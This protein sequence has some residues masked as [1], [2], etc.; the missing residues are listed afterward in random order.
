MFRCKEC[1]TEYEIKPEYCDCGNDTFDE[2]IEKKEDVVEVLPKNAEVKVEKNENK[3]ENIEKQEIKT[4]IKPKSKLEQKSIIS[5]FAWVIFL[6]CIFSALIILLFPVKTKVETTKVQEATSVSTSIPDINKLWNNTPASVEKKE[7]SKII[8]SQTSNSQ[9]TQTSKKDE[10][11][12]VQ[13]QEKQVKSSSN[14]QTLQQK[15]ASKKTSSSTN[16]TAK[17]T[18]SQQN[19]SVVKNTTT[20]AK[21]QTTAVQ[22]VN[23]QELS[24][25]MIKLR[26]NIASKIDFTSVVGDGSC[27]FSFRVLSNGVLTDK[28][29]TNLSDNESLNETVYNALRNTNSFNPPPSG[30]NTNT[31][32]KL[33]VKMYNN[34]FEVSLL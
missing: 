25:Y 18:S 14:T 16:K 7:T 13:M 17:T 29:A 34:S 21:S 8:D 4:E 10:V 33:H 9:N 31:V 19:S 23:K 5:P 30:Y 28:K 20:Q 2:I 26:N 15:L 11:K 32:L 6:L 24:S 22:T 3:I 1:Q 12:S 27:T